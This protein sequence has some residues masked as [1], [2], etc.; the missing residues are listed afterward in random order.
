M[1]SVDTAALLNQLLVLHYRSLPMYLAEATPW[2]GRGMEAAHETLI[3]I[4]E[5]HASMVARL[6]ELILDAGGAV[7]SGK[8]PL[9]FTAYNDLA[10]E[11]FLPLLVDCQR[12][13]IEAIEVCV[14]QLSLVPH[15]QAVAQETL[16]AAKGHLE[17]LLECE[18]QIAEASA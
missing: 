14:E 17:S 8:F 5:D 4:A 13:T 7:E 1:E 12:R 18:K 6:S 9:R 11:Y 15:A 2:V 10:I 16:G 3:A